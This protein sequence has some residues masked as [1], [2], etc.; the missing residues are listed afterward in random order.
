MCERRHTPDTQRAPEINLWTDLLHGT[1]IRFCFVDDYQPNIVQ[2]P[3]I[4]HIKTFFYSVVGSLCVCFAIGSEHVS[5]L[6]AY[7]PFG[8][9]LCFTLCSATDTVCF[10]LCVFLLL[11]RRVLCIRIRSR[12]MLWNS[13][14]IW[15]FFVTLNCT[16]PNE[17][18]QF[19]FFLSIICTCVYGTNN[20]NVISTELSLSHLHTPTEP[21]TCD[22]SAECITVWT[23]Y[24]NMLL[25][26]CGVYG[27]ISTKLV[28]LLL[29]LFVHI[30]IFITGTTFF[31]LFVQFTHNKKWF[32]RICFIWSI[33]ITFI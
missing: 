8:A 29:K 18:I 14:E 21:K 28:T 26:P 17:K 9:L 32:V 7:F 5:A 20:L 2:P 25:F 3:E 31:F 1:H 10:V 11:L 4:W 13:L 12:Q 27:A 16:H 24:W 22:S 33:F 6:L 19:I 23:K 30:C 15:I